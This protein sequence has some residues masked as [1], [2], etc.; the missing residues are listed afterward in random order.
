M[1][2]LVV[3]LI[4]LPLLSEAGQVDFS[5]ESNFQYSGYVGYQQ[6][7][8]TADINQSFSSAEPQLGLNLIYNNRNFQLFNQFRFGTNIETVA[9]YNFAQYTFNLAE[10]TNF[11]IRGGKVQHELGLYNTSRIDPR[12]RQGVIMPQSIYWNTFENFFTS[13]VGVEALLQYKDIIFTYTIDDPTITNSAEV[14]KMMTG[15]LLNSMQT[16]FGSHQNV[17]I[18]YSPRDLPLVLKTTHTRFNFGNDTSQYMTLYDNNQIG[19]DLIAYVTTF[20]AEYKIGDFQLSAETLIFTKSNQ[21]WTDIA[22]MNKGYSFTGVY[23]LFDHFD[24]RLNYNQYVS[25][26]T[27]FYSTNPWMGYYKDTNVGIN[28]HPTNN[29]MFQLEGHHIN[30]GRTVYTTD[31]NLD[32]YKEWYMINFNAIYS[33]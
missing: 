18:T 12:T 23:S 14:R 21:R 6:V 30:G 15:P 29:L 33:F 4:T 32:Q 5:P 11:S 16:T 9:V 31:S 2:K 27:K 3:L 7:S 28:F 24:L 10:E 20:G 22:D 1:K 26:E 25:N 13:G 8:G 17:S 19:K